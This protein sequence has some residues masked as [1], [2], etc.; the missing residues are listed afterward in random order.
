MTEIPRGSP[1][2]RALEK[3][4]VCVACVLLEVPTLDCNGRVY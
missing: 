2:V 3:I 1:R 4:R